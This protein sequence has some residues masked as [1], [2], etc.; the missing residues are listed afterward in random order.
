MDILS[1]IKKAVSE[2]KVYAVLVR[3][4]RGAALHMGI[5]FSLDEAYA[6]ARAR[7]QAMTQHNPNEAIDIELW[8]VMSAR[9]VVAQFSDPSSVEEVL[10]TIQALSPSIT[11]QSNDNG[12]PLPALFAPA[13]QQPKQEAPAPTKPQGTLRDSVQSVRE[14]RNVLMKQLI[15][16]GDLVLVDKFKE[17]LGPHSSR[18]VKQAITKNKPP[19][20]TSPLEG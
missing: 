1:N 17:L 6:S 4:S 12:N 9:Q 14:S 13:V 11:E 16:Q 20:D 5:H 2:A 19:E 10:K 18:Y 8:N 7:M 15:A 3:S